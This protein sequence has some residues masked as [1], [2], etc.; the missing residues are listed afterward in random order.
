M[1]PA[2]FS[3]DITSKEFFVSDLFSLL[4]VFVSCDVIDLTICFEVDV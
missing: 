2:G 3:A 4:D 1:I